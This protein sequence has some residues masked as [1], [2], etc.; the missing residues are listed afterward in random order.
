MLSAMPS[1]RQSSA[2][3]VSPRRPSSTM[4]IFSSAAWCFRVARRM[5]RTSVSDDAGVELDFCRAT[6]SQKSSVPQAISFVSQVLKR[7]STHEKFSECR[8][9]PPYGD[10]M[11]YVAV[12]T[13][14]TSTYRAANTDGVFQHGI[15][16]RLYVRR[17]TGDNAEYL[18]SGLF[19]LQ[20]LIAFAGEARDL[21]FL[22]GR[23][24]TTTGHR[25]GCS[26][27]ALWRRRLVARRFTCF[28][29]CF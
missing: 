23:C 28:A 5:L 26:S 17:R 11:Q 10:M 29:T 9:C 27:T 21:R 1:R 18:G 24:R 7:D 2:I 15:E 22:G 4:R 3:D 16:H 6:M 19:P 13:T 25:F 20:R 12:P 14:D 8:L